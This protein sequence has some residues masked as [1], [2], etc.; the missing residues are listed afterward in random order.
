[1]IRQQAQKTTLLGLLTCF[2]VGSIVSMVSGV[3]AEGSRTLYP[4]P[5]SVDSRANLEWRPADLYGNLL[6]RSSL[7]K[8]YARKDEYILLGSS[9]VG[10]GIGGISVFY[11]ATA[12]TQQLG[13]V[14]H[15]A[16]KWVLP[17][18]WEKSRRAQWS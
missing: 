7:M 17:W 2:V 9:A 6:P 8:V 11:P 10:V 15:S 4:K 13:D 18:P 16:L 1:V 14:R 12:G 5:S 3:R